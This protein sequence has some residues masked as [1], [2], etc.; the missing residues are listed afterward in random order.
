MS[1]GLITMTDLIPYVMGMYKPPFRWIADGE[2][3]GYLYDGRGSMFAYYRGNPEGP[4]QFQL[5][6]W[7]FGKNQEWPSHGCQKALLSLCEDAGA[8][9]AATGWEAADLLTQFWEQQAAKS[10]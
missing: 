7:G 9:K 6:P 1:G 4:F 3:T 8:I 5:Q 10:K 2:C